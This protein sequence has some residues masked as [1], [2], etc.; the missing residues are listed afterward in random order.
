MKRRDV[1]AGLAA[2]GFGSPTEPSGQE[3]LYI[4]KPQRVEDRKMLHDF[5]DEFAFVELVTSCSGIRISHIPVLLDRGIGNYGTLYGHISRQNPQ[6]EAFDGQHPAVIVFRGPHSYI[7]PT[8]YATTEAVP[9]W[10]FAVVQATGKLKAIMDEKTLRDLLTRLIQKFEHEKSDYNL[11]KLPDTFTRRM[12]AGIVGFEME[13]QRLEGKF[14]LGQ[15][16]SD[17]DRKG[18]LRGL[19]SAKQ[20]R[21]LCDLTESVY[22]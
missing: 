21:S 2:A 18:I 6:A 11:G 10:N 16:R 3:S 19:R 8:W 14:K 17:A 13:I 20:P 15:E 12:I 1:M 9:T 4:P 7:S 5:M 22:K